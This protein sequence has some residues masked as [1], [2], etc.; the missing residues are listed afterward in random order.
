[1]FGSVDHQPSAEVCFVAIGS[2]ER[3]ERISQCKMSRSIT[4]AVQKE[5]KRR[6]I[7]Y[8]KTASCS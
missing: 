7:A 6:T 1:M 3:A 5:G 2:L 4:V 8:M